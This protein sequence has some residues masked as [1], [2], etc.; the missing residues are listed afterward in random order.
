MIQLMINHLTFVLFFLLNFIQIN[1]V[2]MDDIKSQEKLKI[3]TE[4]TTILPNSFKGFEN[5]SYDV[6]NIILNR[7]L[8]RKFTELEE[9]SQRLK[10]RL[11]DVT[12]ADDTFDIDEE[13]ENDLNTCPDEDDIDRHQFDWSHFSTLEIDCNASEQKDGSIHFPDV[14]DVGVDNVD[15]LAN[16]L[17]HSVLNISSIR[18][19]NSPLKDE[20]ISV[21]SHTSE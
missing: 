7:T 3:L 20:D 5:G 6:D 16:A 14:N 10:S 2:P 13:F 21:N 11:L 12:T 18:C 17:Q 4:E 15:L 19:E 8:K 1:I 9:I